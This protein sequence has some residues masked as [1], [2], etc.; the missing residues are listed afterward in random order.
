MG[1]KESPAMT[2]VLTATLAFAL[3]ASAAVPAA[4]QDWFGI[5]A[6]RDADLFAAQQAIR[7]RDIQITNDIARLESQMQTA[8]G[9]SDLA[10]MRVRPLVPAIPANPNAPPPKIDTS[11]LAQI[12][13]AALAA[14]NARVRA[15]SENKR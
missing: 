10:A 11:K 3:A 14:S 4:A 5:T 12:P 15:A 8:Q 13:D 7:Q 9:L 6:A 1:L 2:R